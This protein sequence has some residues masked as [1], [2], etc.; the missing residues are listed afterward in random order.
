MKK[1]YET[2]KIEIIELEV[3]DIITASNPEDPFDGK[4]QPLGLS[5][6]DLPI[7]QSLGF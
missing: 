6:L 5:N 7:D 1:I 4:E 3:Q 2:A